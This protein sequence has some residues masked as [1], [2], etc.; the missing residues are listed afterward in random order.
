LFRNQ[1]LFLID[2]SLAYPEILTQV[3]RKASSVQPS[4]EKI[5]VRSVCD[6][7]SGQFLIIATGW[8]KTAWRNTILFRTRLVDGAVVIE[9]DNFEEGLSEELIIAGKDFERI[10]PKLSR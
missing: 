10:Y 5:S 9:D 4:L 1:V 2:K 3:L 6:R 7:E 8:T